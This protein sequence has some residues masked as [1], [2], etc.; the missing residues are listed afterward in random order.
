MLA[1]GVGIG[2]WLV[3]S[4]DP[5]R[6]RPSRSDD[7]SESSNRLVLGEALRDSDGDQRVGDYSVSA[8]APVASRYGY[9]GAW[10][11]E[12][13]LEDAGEPDLPPLPFIHVGERWYDPASGRFLQRDP[14]GIDG[15]LNVFAYVGSNPACASDPF[16][17]KVPFS[18]A[19]DDAGR[20]GGLIGSGVGAVAGGVGGSTVGGLPGGLAGAGV[21]AVIGYEAGEVAGRWCGFWYWAG[22]YLT[23]AVNWLLAPP[24]ILPPPPPFVG[25]PLPP[26]YR[27][28]PSPEPPGRPVPPWYC[29]PAGT[30]VHTDTG[31]LPIEELRHGSVLRS[32]CPES[33]ASGYST[34]RG[35]RLGTASE[36]I[37]LALPGE[38]IHCTA[39]HPFW[40]D[41]VGW[42]TAGHLHVGA[43]LIDVSGQLIPILSTERLSLASP[44]PVY[45][46]ST[47][48]HHTYF[49]GRS[50]ILV[51]NKPP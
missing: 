36:F 24:A 4:V 5:N 26:G 27:P 49:V 9:A 43:M 51:H 21:G 13:G 23:P 11:Y 2:R 48:E 14:I 19:V 25:P 12:T 47:D 10:G 6:V 50:G 3:R 32:S 37:R 16:G 39:E 17:L 28:R 35:I 15:G 7:P 18:T 29:F 45:T 31:S 34:V 20:V 44:I 46:L 42:R 33:R 30:A 1:D 38:V 40:V 41:G 22:Q 8:T